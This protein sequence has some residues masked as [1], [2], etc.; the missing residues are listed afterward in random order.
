MVNAFIFILAACGC[1]AVQCFEKLPSAYQISYGNPD[2]PVKAVEYFSFSCLKCLKQ[3]TEDFDGMKKKYI[4]T[5]KVYWTF[6]PDPADKLTLQALVCLRQLDD[7]QKRLFIEVVSRNMDG[8]SLGAGCQM[9]QAAMEYFHHPLPE[10]DKI[11]FL[12]TTEEFRCAFAFLKQK[13]VVANVPTLEVNGKIRE[14]F[15]SRKFLE[16]HFSHL[17][18]KEAQPCK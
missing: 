12:E 11:S 8:K 15:P 9:M 10:L 18:G 4:D 16:K 1:S 3:I 5:G 7:V 6:H 14:E 13:D 2:A 17:L